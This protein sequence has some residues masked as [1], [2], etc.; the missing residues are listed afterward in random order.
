MHPLL[1]SYFSRI[2]SRHPPPPPGVFFPDYNFEKYIPGSELELYSVLCIYSLLGVYFDLDVY[3]N[4][5][6]YLTNVSEVGCKRLKFTK[7]F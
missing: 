6:A 1:L 5:D 4:V 2:S 7:L 3:L